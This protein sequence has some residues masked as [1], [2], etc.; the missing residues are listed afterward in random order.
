M[1]YVFKRPSNREAMLQFF[2]GDQELVDRL[3]PPE[4]PPTFLYTRDPS[5]AGHVVTFTIFNSIP[6]AKV[7]D[8]A[9]NRIQEQFRNSIRDTAFRPIP[10][11]EEI[12]A[13][14][15]DALDPP[16][17]RATRKKPGRRPAAS[18]AAPAA[19]PAARRRRRRR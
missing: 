13:T 1:L 5:V 15:A 18:G 7:T 14:F 11:S 2:R 10:F 16:K 12:D 4:T 19:R 17:K 8:E 6:A 3:E 9:V